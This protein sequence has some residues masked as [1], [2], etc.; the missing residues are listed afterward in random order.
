MIIKKYDDEL[1]S[2]IYFSS[3]DLEQLY[4]RKP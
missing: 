3:D 2:P 4:L 1:K